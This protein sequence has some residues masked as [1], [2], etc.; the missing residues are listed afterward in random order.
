MSVFASPRFLRNVMLADAASCAACGA[1]QLG[2]T[3]ALVQWLALPAALL[4]GTGVFLLVY[5]AIV[6]LIGTRVP[7]SRPV[8]GLCIAGN[9]GWAVACLLL[10]AS[11]LVQPSGLGS[12]YVL[13][14]AVTV[15]LLTAMQW[16]GL[17]RA[18]T[19]PFSAA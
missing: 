10:L 15:L 3:G 17:R 5:A 13:I 1:L 6:A 9:L 4:L 11:G 19:S 12:A 7:V 2:A 16:L 18:V 8:V 14:Q